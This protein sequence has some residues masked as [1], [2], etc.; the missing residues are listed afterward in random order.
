MITFES[1]ELDQTSIPHLKVLLCGIN[2]FGAEWC[3]HISISCYIRKM[4]VLLLHKTVLVTFLLA[5]NVPVG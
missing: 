5:I 2:A 3:G 4:L 1:L